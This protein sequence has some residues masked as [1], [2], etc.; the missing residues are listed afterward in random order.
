[1][2]WLDEQTSPVAIANWEQPAV[3]NR[4]VLIIYRPNTYQFAGRTATTYFD[5]VTVPWQPAP[6]PGCG[7]SG[8]ATCDDK[9]GLIALLKAVVPTQ[10]IDQKKIFVTGAS[11]GGFFTLE[12]MCSPTTNLLFRGFGVVSANLWSTGPSEDASTNTC[13]SF[14][15]DSSVMF[16]TGEADGLIRYGGAVTGERYAWG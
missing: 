4:F 6:I 16:I 2:I 1:M 13:R 8:T 11:K 10:H 14:N 12:V 5:P 3:A 7:V 15:R 9:P